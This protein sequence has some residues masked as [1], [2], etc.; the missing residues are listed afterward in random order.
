MWGNKRAPT[1][2]WLGLMLLSG[3]IVRGG[4]LFYTA[5]KFSP[6]EARE[7]TTSTITSAPA[8]SKKRLVDTIQGCRKGVCKSMLSSCLPDVPR[9]AVYPGARPTC[10]P[11]STLYHMYAASA[12]IQSSGC[13]SRSPVMPQAPCHTSVVTMCCC[14]V[15]TSPVHLPSPPFNPL[16]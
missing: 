11:R 6:R 1:Q 2:S 12:Y 5:A 13:L 8:S 7:T 15:G 16:N 9:W 10:C 4:D 14:C 3:G